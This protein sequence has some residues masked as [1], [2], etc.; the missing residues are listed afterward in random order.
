LFSAAEAYVAAHLMDFPKELK[1]RA[2]PRGI[3][4]TVPLP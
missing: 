1:I 3:R 4:I 2:I